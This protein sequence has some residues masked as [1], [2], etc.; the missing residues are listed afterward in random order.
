MNE[1]E[2]YYNEMEEEGQGME[3]YTS[4]LFSDDQSLQYDGVA[5]INFFFSELEK[6]NLK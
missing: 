6:P 3:K 5:G 2:E 4:L 1:I